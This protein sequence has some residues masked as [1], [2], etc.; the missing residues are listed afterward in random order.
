[1]LAVLVA[2]HVDLVRPLS[3]LEGRPFFALEPPSGG[4]FFNA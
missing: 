3:P 2:I 1:M 4:E